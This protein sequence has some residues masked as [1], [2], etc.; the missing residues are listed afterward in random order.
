VPVIHLGGGR[1]ESF[2]VTDVREEGYLRDKRKPLLLSLMT[3]LEIH[4]EVC[5]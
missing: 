1:A 5:L 4:A 2:V 3:N